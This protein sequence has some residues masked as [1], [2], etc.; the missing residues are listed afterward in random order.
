MALVI[1]AVLGMTALWVYHKGRTRMFAIETQQRA[2]LYHTDTKDL[3]S[4]CEELWAIRHQTV[5]PDESVDIPPEDLHLPQTII[6]LHAHLITVYPNGV[7]IE[8][9]GSNCH[10]GVDFY[11]AGEPQGTRVQLKAMYPSRQ[12]AAGLWYYAENGIVADSA[13]TP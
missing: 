11:Q 8:C 13:R 3:L 12:L 6:S 1:V 10:F 4:D 5:P 2:L 7:R 9:G